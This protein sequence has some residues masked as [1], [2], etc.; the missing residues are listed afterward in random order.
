MKERIWKRGNEKKGRRVL[1]MKG[2]DI[3]GELR[4]GDQHLVGIA[5]HDLRIPQQ[6]RTH[7][8]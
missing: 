4:G 2:V 3:R 8:N 1:E 5:R 6:L 7:G